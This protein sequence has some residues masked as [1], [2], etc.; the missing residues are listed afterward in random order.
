MLTD[1]QKLPG[2]EET[3]PDKN[4]AAVPSIDLHS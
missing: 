3:A 1:K 4:P 2:W